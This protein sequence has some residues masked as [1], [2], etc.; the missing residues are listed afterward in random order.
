VTPFWLAPIV[1]LYGLFKALFI[2]LNWN[3]YFLAL[4]TSQSINPITAT[5]INIPTQTPA[6]NM[7]PMIRQLS[8]LTAN[9]D[10][11]TKILNEGMRFIV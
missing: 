3:I 7:S 8:R 9:N 5:T 1:D 6:L 11:S 2:T 10:I 4:P